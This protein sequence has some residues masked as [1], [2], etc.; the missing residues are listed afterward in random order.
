MLFTLMLKK[1]AFERFA[2]SFA[3][4]QVVH[5]FF[6]FLDYLLPLPL[7]YGPVFIM[8]YH[9][10]TYGKTGDKIFIFA[11]CFL[12]FF[13]L[14]W[15]LLETGTPDQQY[16]ELY[17]PALIVSLVS[18][19]LIVLVKM[20]H[21]MINTGSQFFLLR[22]LA[23]LG[24]AI[25]FFVGLLLLSH[26]WGFELD[27]NPLYVV[28]LVMIF[29]I[30]LILNYL[31][32]PNEVKPAPASWELQPKTQNPIYDIGP[33]QHCGEKLAACM[34]DEKLFLNAN[35]TLDDLSQLT[36]MPK[37]QI[38]EYVNQ[39]LQTNYY[40]WLAKYRIDYARE[41]L[42]KDDQFLKME[43]LANESGF[44]SKTSFYRYF[45]QF[46]G[47]PPSAYRDNIKN[48]EW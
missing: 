48:S 14:L 27:V 24:N 34:R 39:H 12:F 13:F 18:Y 7:L 35:L 5:I 8:M 10:A 33:M 16:Y 38:T 15:Y 40:E 26:E 21:H 23:L 19:P 22:Q 46:V 3:F 30:V 11:H 45:N 20:R 31:L 43:V 9:I 41:L 47:M 25:G 6:I 36:D 1:N 42:R 2:I 29:S 4:M 44:N 37:N 17:F 28:A 32:T